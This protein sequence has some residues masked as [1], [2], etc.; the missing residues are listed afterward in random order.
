MSQFDVPVGNLNQ[1]TNVEVPKNAANV[2]LSRHLMSDPASTATTATAFGTNYERE[3]FPILT[4]DV[5]DANQETTSYT[6]VPPTTTTT[7]GYGDADKEEISI[8]SPATTFGTTSPYH[9]ATIGSRTAA[10]NHTTLESDGRGESCTAR[11]RRGNPGA[12][13]RFRERRREREK[14]TAAALEKARSELQ[15]LGIR[16]QELKAEN[17]LLREILSMNERPK[18]EN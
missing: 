10:S 17:K 3:P 11:E 2:D 8:V 12:S 16:I 5:Y 14:D 18:S 9:T 4:N 7:T 6:P 15:E 13:A 1:T